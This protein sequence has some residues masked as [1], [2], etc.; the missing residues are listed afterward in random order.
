MKFV[1]F[2]KEM[3]GGKKKLVIFTV[4]SILIY[5]IVAIQVVLTVKISDSAVVPDI[6][7]SGL[8]SGDVISFEKYGDIKSGFT[9]KII[10]ELNG[11]AEAYELIERN[12]ITVQKENS[13]E[14]VTYSL[15]AC[16]H[17]FFEERVS[18]M[19]YEGNIPQEGK[20][21]AVV[22]G[23]L[24]K[25]FDIQI[26]D[27]ITKKTVELPNIGDVEIVLDLSGDFEE[28]DYEVVG[29]LD[30]TDGYFD[31]AFLIGSETQ[32][33]YQGNSIWTYFS[34]EKAADL[35]VE[36]IVDAREPSF[37]E[38]GIGSVSE[39]Y[40]NKDSGLLSLILENGYI[41]ML[42]IVFSYIIIAYVLKGVTYKLGI[43]KAIGISNRYIYGCYFVGVSAIQLVSYILSILTMKCLC[44]GLNHTISVA[45]GFEVNIYHITFGMIFIMTLMLV[46]TLA[47]FWVSLWY[48]INRIKPKMAMNM[49]S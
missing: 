3:F 11:Q 29:V 16:P 10:N 49:K 28:I 14:S 6:V 34:D 19:M 39:T 1:L 41:F 40:R 32:P 30:A 43:M 36:N 4:L 26:G 22:G 15:F 9:E 31:Y 47:T 13:L 42:V 20:R 8:I 46:V 37:Y 27:V 24:A 38:Y 33:G 45:Y 2:S 18:S 25:A 5:T 21:Q 44:I 12:L 48:K 17:N 7:F 35:Y 23:Y